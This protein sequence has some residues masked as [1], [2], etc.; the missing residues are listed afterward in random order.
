MADSSKEQVLSLADDSGPLVVKRGGLSIRVE[1]NSSGTAD[2]F[3]NIPVTMHAPANDDA[4]PKAAPEI[5]DIALAGEH[6]GKIYGGILPS[7]NKPS[8]FRRHLS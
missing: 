2:V 3:T 8:G 5:G 1:F 6:K 4:R 7:D